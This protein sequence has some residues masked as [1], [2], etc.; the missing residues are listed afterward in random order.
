[1][2]DIESTVKSHGDEEGDTRGGAPKRLTE[3]TGFFAEVGLSS[4]QAVVLRHE[5]RRSLARL[6]T[7]AVLYTDAQCV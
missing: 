1:M 5:L 7:T 4:V 2:A 6:D 3:D